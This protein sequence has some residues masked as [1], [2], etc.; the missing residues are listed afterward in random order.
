MQQ[1]SLWI[2]ALP[3]VQNGWTFSAFVVL[4]AVWLSLRRH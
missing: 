4:I 1:L 3:Y 2:T